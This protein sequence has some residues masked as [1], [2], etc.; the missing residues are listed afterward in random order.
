MV[1]KRILKGVFI[2][3]LVVLTILTAAVALVWFNQNQIKQYAV[4]QVN[5]YLKAPVN[6]QEI[7]IAFLQQFPR[8]SLRFTQVQIADALRPKRSLFEAQR[9]YIA[10]DFWDIITRKYTIKQIDIDSGYCWLHTNNAG[11]VNY[12]IWNTGSGDTTPVWLQLKQIRLQNVRLVYDDQQAKQW[13]DLHAKDVKVGLAIEKEMQAL[14]VSG[15]LYLHQLKQN[16]YTLMAKREVK[17]ETSTTYNQQTKQF[18]IQEGSFSIGLLPILIKGDFTFLPNGT[19][20]NANFSAPQATIGGLLE[21]LPG[22]LSQRVAAYPSDGKIYLNGLVNGL[23]TA[24]GQPK[25]TIDFGI[26]DGKVETPYAVFSNIATKGRFTNGAQQSMQSAALVLQHVELTIGN[27]KAS[28][29]LAITN[30]NNPFVSI[31]ADAQVEAATMLRV[32]Q[33]KAVKVASGD[34]DFQIRLKGLLSDLTNKQGFSRCETAGHIATK[35]QKITLESGL[36]IE[37]LV[38]SMQVNGHDLVIEEVKLQLNESNL[39]LNGTLR[40]AIPYL[41]TSNQLLKADL[42]CKSSSIVLN[43]LINTSSNQSANAQPVQLSRNIELGL[44]F[45]VN[46]LQWNAFNAQDVSGKLVWRGN[47]I[48]VPV[49]TFKSMDGTSKL[50]GSIEGLSTGDYAVTLH[51]ECKQVALEKLFFQCNNFGQGALTDKHLRGSLTAMVD[52]LGIWNQQLVC[53]LPKLKATASLEIKN[54]QLL[55]YEP[56]Y[57]LSKFVKM[58]DLKSLRFEDLKNTIFIENETIQIPQMDV[59][60]NALNLAV[61]GN[62]TFTN[63][64]DYHLKLKLNDVLAKRFKQRQSAFDEEVLD[65]GTY[66][67]ISMKGPIDHLVFAYDKKMARKQMQEQMKQERT[68]VKKI[69]RAELGLDKDSIPQKESNTDELEFEPE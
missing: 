39:A 22:S 8:V 45:D 49:L 33:Q 68:E 17:L 58:D 57:E 61:S 13:I 1:H 60:N 15:N 52:M 67:Y 30:F 10:F 9:V 54:G 14:E 7:D 6:V 62:H 19:L 55:N 38:A 12:Q 66:L 43:Q 31:E 65:E 32:L 5:T 69:W 26:A 28:G 36:V 18:V 20:V 53:D 56:L 4:S 47:K 63:L 42:V 37:Q 29:S 27:G 64:L 35:L 2:T 34:I 24:T 21:L 25:I 48:D 11:K 51:A 41:L 46:K 44:L 40:N 3:L 59:R 50:T 16:Q 23:W